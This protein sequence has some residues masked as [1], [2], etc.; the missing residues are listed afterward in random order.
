MSV[1]L[2][3]LLVLLCVLVFCLPGNAV[4]AFGAGNIPRSVA[5]EIGRDP[6]D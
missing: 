4:Y 2:F 1:N 5:N 3:L 6:P